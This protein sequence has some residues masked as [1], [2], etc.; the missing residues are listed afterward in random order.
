MG[1][2]SEPS[3]P[4]IGNPSGSTEFD[5]LVVG[6]G[7]SGAV[8]AE[9]LASECNFRVL[10]VDRRNHLAGNAHDSHDASGVLLHRH[11]PHYFRT[12]SERVKDYLSR[13]TEWRRVDYRILS[14]ADGRHWQFPV[15]LNTFEQWIGRT[16][17]SREM[18]RIV[19]SWRV[20]IAEPANFEEE[21]LS[22]LGRPLYEKFFRNYTRK[23]W[24]LDPRELDA[25]LGR[26][27]QFRTDRDDR[28]FPERFQ[29]LPDSGYTAMFE[30][31]LRDPRITVRLG[32]DHHDAM[33]A[34]R[35]RH[36]VYTGAVDEFFAHR[37][38]RLPYR[39][40]RFET[41]TLPLEY[42]QSAVQVNYPNDHDFTRI[43]EIKHATGQRLPVTTI[44]REYPEEFAP[45][46]EPYYPVPSASA[47]ELRRRYEELAAT[48]PH[49]SF[50]GRLARYRY[51]NMDQVVAAALTE[52]DKLRIMLG[53]RP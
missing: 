10:L 47:R 14:W 18:E 51:Y 27:I 9:R 21:I 13:F 36:M 31:M 53:S 35:F 41:E 3:V 32:A 39:S 11:G 17:D 44:V 46:R 6:A 7:F 25:S 29:A 12:D 2:P 37:L 16:S 34:C 24:N 22:R 38:G 4:G 15:N 1:R 33:A 43:V 40:L 19:S 23:Q 26:R 49:V 30:R 8:L 48:L 42:H 52:S 28:C 50:V 20:P 45:G 5:I